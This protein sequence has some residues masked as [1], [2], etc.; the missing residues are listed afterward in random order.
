MHELKDWHDLVVYHGELFD[1]LG[2]TSPPM[3]G[4]SFGGMVA[5]EIAAAMPKSVDGLALIDPVGLWRDD[6]PVKN[7]M[8]IPHKERPA[9]LFANPEG[10]AAK[11]FF[12][13]PTEEDERVETMSMLTWSQAC[14][15]KFAWPIADRG[16]A[17]RIHRIAAP[18]LIVWGEQDGVI[19]PAYAEE[20][21]KR[22]AGSR[23]EMIERAAHMAHL[24]Q[25]D[26]VLKALSGFLEK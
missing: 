4:H 2:L 26:A 13:V 25:P 22:I 18:T 20:F 3:I 11:R 24:E 10:D 16:L 21:A 12:V 17:K 7:W 14:T 23:I 15:G 19:A 1:K 8:L 6:M 5:A 9:A